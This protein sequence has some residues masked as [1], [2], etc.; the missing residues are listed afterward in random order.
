V[1]ADDGTG[2]V[3]PGR[4][5]RASVTAGISRKVKSCG[6]PDEKSEETIVCAGQRIDQEG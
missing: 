3:S 2:E 6:M 1:K 4:W 5:Y